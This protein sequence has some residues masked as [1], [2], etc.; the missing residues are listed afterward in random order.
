MESLGYKET[1]QSVPVT[2]ITLN[3]TSG[4]VNIGATLSLTET[5]SPSNAQNKSVTW[6]SSNTKIATVTSSGVVKGI[7]AGTANIT[8]TTTD[9]GKTATCRVT[10]INPTVATTG[11]T[12]SKTSVTLTA[13]QGTTL[14]ATIKPSNATNKS[15][16]WTSSNPAVATVNASGYVKAVKRG[17][18]VITAKT[19]SGGKTAT[20]TVTVNP[21]DKVEAFVTRLYRV[22]LERE[23]DDG[24]LT[25]W[26][27]ELKS[28]RSTGADV[29]GGFYLSKE[30]RDRRLSNSRYVELAYTGI[31][32][33]NPDSEGKSYWTDCLDSGAS[34]DYMV[35]GF[36]GSQEF[37]DLCASYGI[38]R[39][40]RQPVEA[41]DKN[42]GITKYVSRLYTK[43]LGRGYDADGLN[44]WCQQILNDSSRANVINVAT[45]GFFH[46]AEFRRKNLDNGAFVK[47]LYRTFLGREYDQTGYQYWK[48]KLDSGQMSR[49][50]VI[51]AFAYSE[52]FSGIMAQYGL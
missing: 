38:K 7:S 49:D 1:G 17:K 10:V 15:V 20:C 21:S 50:D 11:V 29:V 37:T 26:V 51:N 13:G 34:Y 40:N 9:G 44:Y 36:I 18:A 35:C 25:Y 2:G 4:S 43:A 30:M 45:G 33:R 28:G 27:A 42:I 12:I 24:G 6:R 41:R 46:S 16:V 52:E 5:V 23:P 22:V 19:A 39:G 32:G 14:T 3:K 31:M 47:V 48:G 8:V